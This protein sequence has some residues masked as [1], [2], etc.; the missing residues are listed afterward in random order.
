MLT[1]CQTRK[2]ARVRREESDAPIRPADACCGFV[3]QAL[4]AEPPEITGIFKRAKEEGYLSP[5]VCALRAKH[6]TRSFSG[7]FSSPQFIRIY[8]A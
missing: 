2:V 8:S 5:A 6:T 3:G 1:V 4:S 7:S